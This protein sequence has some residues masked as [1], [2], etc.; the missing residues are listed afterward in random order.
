M[1]M[2]FAALFA[3]AGSLPVALSASTIPITT[4]SFFNLTGTLTVS[5]AN[6]SNPTITFSNLAVPNQGVIGDPVGGTFLTANAGS[7]VAGQTVGMAQLNA[8]AEPVGS[9]FSDPSWLVFAAIDNLPTLTLTYIPVGVD[10]IAG[11]AATPPAASQTCTPPI[12]NTSNPGPFSFQNLSSSSSSVSFSFSGVTSDGLDIWSGTFTSQFTTESFQDVLNTLANQGSVGNTF[13][14][15]VT[16]SQIPEPGTYLMLGV[17]L[18]L[19]GLMGR[20]NPR[21]A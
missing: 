10:T 6:I 8:L 15:T 5:N 12:G 2:K 21:R 16:F 19:I 9:A 11:C 1:T 20:R 7:T 13:S 3:L 18:L 14:G 4:G 17:G